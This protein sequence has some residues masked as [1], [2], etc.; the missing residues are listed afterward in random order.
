[1]LDCHLRKKISSNTKL[2]HYPLLHPRMIHTSS[3]TSKH[4]SKIY[5]MESDNFI[6]VKIRN[7]S[8]KKIRVRSFHSWSNRK[9]FDSNKK[10]SRISFLLVK[11]ETSQS[12]KC[13]SDHFTFTFYTHTF[14]HL[15]TLV[16]HHF[17]S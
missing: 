6:L 4:N 8:I 12:K 1:M 17:M 7:K 2:S 3:Y 11:L 5:S 9:Q 16:E 14:R 10:P 15:T 13:E